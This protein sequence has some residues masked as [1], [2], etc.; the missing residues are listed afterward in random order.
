MPYNA[1]TSLD[2]VGVLAGNA[3]LVQMDSRFHRIDCRY[4]RESGTF[5]FGCC[6][7]S[8]VV[9]ASFVVWLFGRR[10]ATGCGAGRWLGA[11]APE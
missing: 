11:G 3:K 9:L 4:T 8:V 2:L 5:R 10:A 6:R 1:G 7:R